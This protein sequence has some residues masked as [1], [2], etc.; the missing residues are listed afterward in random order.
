MVS[1][2]SNATGTIDFGN[3]TLGGQTLTAI[4][5]ANGT[6]AGTGG[7][8]HNSIWFG[9]LDESQIG[10]M[11]GNTLTVNW[12]TAPNNNFGPVKVIAATYENVSQTT[13]VVDSASNSSTATATIQAGSVTVLSSS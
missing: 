13:P 12:D 8:Y 7:G 6:T 3:V 9:Y 1:A 2:E 4:Q 10:S 5:N 11:S